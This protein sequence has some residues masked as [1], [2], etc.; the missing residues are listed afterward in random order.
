[1]SERLH[2]LM[3]TGM[4]GAGRSTAIHVL[5]D[6]GFFC[7]DNLPPPLF[8]GLLDLLERGDELQRVGLGVD[9]RTGAFLEGVGEVVDQ[10]R[11]RGH[12]VE[13]IF[14][15]A[16]DEALVRRFSETRR[17]HPLA[18]AGDLLGG[19]Q[20]ERAR[21]GPLREQAAHVFDTTHL[22]VHDLRR[23]LVDHV[24]RGGASPLMVTRVVSFG[25]K[26]GLPVDAD[27]VFDL[28]F[29]PN[30]HFV[31]ELRPKTGLD[32]AVSEYVLQTEDAQELLDEIMSLLENTLPKYER[33]GKSYLTIGIGCTG[34]RHRSVAI[35]EE[36]AKRLRTSREVVVAHRDAGRKLA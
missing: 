18:P 8:A 28:R 33:E 23:S 11:G 6:L 4:S 22:S 34:G 24:A 17:P 29:L 13:M 2:V 10:L 32:A 19:I 36:L 9:V 31:E 30:P 1:M 16:S 12:E 7:V 20:R 35:S 3:V 5:E 14:L 25:F 27:L 21:L 15:D 26:Y